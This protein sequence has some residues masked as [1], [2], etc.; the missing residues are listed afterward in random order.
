MSA[1][2]SSDQRTRSVPQGTGRSVSDPWKA[3]F[4]TLLVVALLAVMT[5]VLLGSRLLVVRQVE[6]IG[7]ERLAEQD[8]VAAVDV[9]TGTP[10]ARVDIE[11]AAQRAEEL[12][13]AQAVTV[14]RGWPATL[15]VEVTERLPVLAIQVGDGFQLVDGE[16]VRIEDSETRPSDYPLVTVKGEVEN[17]PAIA[18]AAAVADELP[19]A[20]L[21]TVN[22]IEASDRSSI[23]LDLDN[24]A[25]VSWGDVDRG[26]DKARVLQVL[27]REHPAAADRRYDVS[28]QGVAVVK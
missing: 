8:V 20:V 13:L 23:V 6:V 7:L 2:E 21:S 14:S 12:R 26:P 5:W 10:L 27:M 28:A 11:A 18:D 9:A 3:A 17:N 25:T 19:P 4:V 1:A 22:T 24:G 16:G 15:V